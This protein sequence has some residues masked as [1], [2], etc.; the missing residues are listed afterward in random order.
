MGQVVLSI[1]YGGMAISGDAM[2]AYEAYFGKNRSSHLADELKVSDDGR[3]DLFFFVVREEPE[4]AVQLASVNDIY[5][6]QISRA[7]RNWEKFCKFAE[8]RGVVLGG[9]ELWLVPNEVA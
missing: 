2:D 9:G 8:K 1:G 3:F 4:T 5:D 7:K 6:K